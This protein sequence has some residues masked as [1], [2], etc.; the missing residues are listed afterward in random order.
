MP[1]VARRGTLPQRL[2]R[3]RRSQARAIA[4]KNTTSISVPECGPLLMWNCPRLAFDQRLVS[5]QNDAGALGGLI[6]RGLRSERL[7]RGC[8]LVV[9][10]PLAAIADPQ[11]HFAEIRQRGGNDDLAAGIGG[12]ASSCRSGSCVI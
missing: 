9:V 1:R 7:H 5:D 2:P 4:R 6:R 12:D 3:C 10:E 11:D 8:D